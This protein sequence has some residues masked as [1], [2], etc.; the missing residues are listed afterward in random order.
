M[1]PSQF[2]RVKFPA[3]KCWKGVSPRHFFHFGGT[4][5]WPMAMDGWD[6]LVL[7]LCPSRIYLVNCY[8]SYSF[9]S[10]PCSISTTMPI[11][12]HHGHKSK[13]PQFNLI[14]LVN[15]HCQKYLCIMKGRS[16]SCFQTLR[17]LGGHLNLN[18]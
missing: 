10:M 1:K 4:P 14:A 17:R 2:C 13:R 15:L 11:A 18:I 16:W 12:H 3:K 8:C 6:Q 5:L 7:A 9:H